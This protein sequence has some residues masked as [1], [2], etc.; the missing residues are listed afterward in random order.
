[1][2][3][4]APR[5]DRDWTVQP[6]AERWLA[7]TLATALADC[8]P[9]AAYADALLDGCGVRLRDILDA[10][11]LPAALLDGAR[12]AGWQP[13]AGA[14]DA[15][16]LENP[17]GYFPAVLP[18]GDDRVRIMF[19]VESID[20]FQAA[21]GQ[22]HAIEGA[23]FGPLRRALAFAGGSS[24]LWAVE[25]NGATV[26]HVEDVGAASIRAGR[27]HL[28]RFRTR[29]RRF[30]SVADG[31]A[32]TETLVDAA[33]A[34]IGPHRACD[35]WLKAEREYWMTRCPA[36]AWAKARQDAAGI[37]WANIDHHTYDGSR[38]HFRVTVR[39]LEKL[40][41][42]LREMLYA[43]EMAG[44]GSQILEQPALKSTIFA[45]VD[46]AP[47][48]IAVDFAHEELPPLDRHRRAGV[49]SILHGESI[50]EGGLNHV[51]GMYD[52][53]R[54]RRLW[55]SEG[56]RMMA[57][58]SDFPFLYQELTEG[59]WA[60]VDP[61]RVD[62][63]E[64]GGHIGAA[65]AENIRLNG[66]IAAHLENLE[67]NEGYKGFNKPGIDGVLRKLD[68]RGAAA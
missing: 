24:D 64:A 62:A 36:G 21:T 27:L 65:E 9:G 17:D 59:D 18:S 50:L 31:L 61:A 14:A 30:A 45:D 68:P 12:A 34:E 23:A 29:Q 8:P 6:D 39:I 5:I 37:G 47:H 3:M 22:Q 51:A 4:A 20:R 42:E 35:L 44:W 28:Q 26:H 25:R 54:L 57:P 46:L 53:S 67:R 55:A 41:Y 11:R 15:G 1:M 56:K 32:Y 7:A 52:N 60:A 13:V 43:G 40:G 58:F 49:L 16:L 48:E 33:V 19:R 38:E 66:A 63:L 10:L 2:A